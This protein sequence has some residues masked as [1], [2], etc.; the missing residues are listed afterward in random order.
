MT[1]I[2]DIAIIFIAILLEAI[3]FILLGSFVAS[4]IEVF[5]SNEKL[6]K[7]IPKNKILSSIVGLGLGL[8]IPVCDCAVIPISKRLIKKGVPINV[9]ITFMLS[10]PIINP[11]VLISTYYAF[12]NG[13][14]D[15]FW[16]RLIGGI[17]I[18]FVIGLIMNVFTN[19]RILI[20]NGKSYGCGCGCL[21]DG[22]EL[23]IKNRIKSVVIH[24][25]KEF[26]DV[27]TY[28]I[29]GAL[30]AS[31][32][33]V[34][35]PQ[36]VLTYFGNNTILSIIVLMIFAYLIS[37]CS[38]ADSFVGKALL[39]NFNETSV[40]A[41]LLVGPMIDIKN[42]MVLLGNYKKKFVITLISLIFL[43]VLIYSMGVMLY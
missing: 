15:I 36:S 27:F 35:L 14:M 40:L 24:M 22:E 25:S 4:L 5:V 32:V 12:G 9:A 37:L 17:V 29:I 42:T 2:K 10:S 19:K 30:I 16:A 7:L 31:C 8:V 39:A 13:N 28:L 20:E 23:T 43:C 34:L 18:A 33:Q 6:V 26:M 1:E 41:F 38:T 21:Q 11:I 3:P